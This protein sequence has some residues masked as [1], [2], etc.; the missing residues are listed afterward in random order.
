[1]SKESAPN[2]RLW[3]RS[4][5]KGFDVE[6]PQEQPRIELT[7]GQRRYL[8]RA[9]IYSFGFVPNTMPYYTEERGIF[10]VPGLNIQW[11][12]IQPIGE[13]HRI[14]SLGA[15]TYNN[16][17]NLVPLDITNHIGRG[18]LSEDFIVHLDTKEAFSHYGVFKN[19]EG[20]N[21]FIQ[22]G[23]ERRVMTSMGLPYH[24]VDYDDFFR[25]ISNSV[26]DLYTKN[27]PQ[28]KWMENT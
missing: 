11:H 10:L 16:P 7:L 21:P 1:M 24:E 17:R 25:Y 22:M 9:W 13:V 27:V 15:R 20:E 23:L 2:I 4:F 12:H 8:S 19:G 6:N 5:D 26:I 18:A 14:D 28:D 3:K